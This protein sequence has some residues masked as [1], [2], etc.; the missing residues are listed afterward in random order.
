MFITCCR[1]F[2]L[3]AALLVLS[4]G[5]AQAGPTGDPP[6]RSVFFGDAGAGL[7]VRVMRGDPYVHVNDAHAYRR[8]GQYRSSGMHPGRG[9]FRHHFV[10]PRGQQGPRMHDPH[11]PHVAEVRDPHGRHAPEAHDPHRYHAP[12]A[13]DPHRYHAPDAHDPHRYH[14]RRTGEPDQRH[15]P[16]TDDPH[17]PDGDGAQQPHGEHFEHRDY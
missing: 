16:R 14:D 3:S 7:Q 1:T 8:H 4:L 9:Q 13:H 6:D 15:D 17:G 10:T 11:R 12:D 2:A 5:A